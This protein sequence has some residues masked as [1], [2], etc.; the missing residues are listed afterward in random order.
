MKQYTDI[1]IRLPLICLSLILLIPIGLYAHEIEGGFQKGNQAYKDGKFDDAISHYTTL[2]VQGYESFELYYNLANAHY[3]LGHIAPSIL[4][5][6]KA[7]KIEP[8][9]ADAQFNLKLANLKVVDKI[10]QKP[11]F[12]LSKWWNSI[13]SSKSS[14]QWATW[15]IILIWFAAAFG[16]L[17]LYSETSRMKRILFF[18]GIPLVFLSVCILLLSIQKR[19][20]EHT[21]SYGIIYSTNTYI[22]SAPEQDAKDLFMLHEGGKVKIREQLDEWTQIELPDGKV[23]WMSSKALKGI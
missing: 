17:F 22:K 14:D 8:S 6:E 9:N 10:P 21:D 16:G 1:L 11:V 23:G 12:V 15:A 5:Y 20:I 18:S 3:K 7:L 13:I 4:Y 2:V 19:S